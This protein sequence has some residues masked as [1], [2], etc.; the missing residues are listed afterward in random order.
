MTNIFQEAIANRRS[1][2]ALKNESPITDE[3]I[4]NRVRFAVKHIPAAFNS[5]S[6]RV[7]VLLHEKHQRLWQI[8]KDTLQA[9]V[10]AEAFGKTKEK[11][12]RSFQSGYGTLLFYEDQRHVRKLME[13]FPRYADKF[14]TWSEHTNAMHQFALWTMLADAGFGASLQHY[15]PLIDERLAKEFNIPTDWKMIAQM[16]FGVAAGQPDE[17]TFLPIDDRVLIP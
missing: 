3:E 6:T 9:I 5:Q 16:P 17:K 11:I 2:Y 10:P 4:I 14:P 13:Q 1:H 15:N 8:T 12:E 7:V